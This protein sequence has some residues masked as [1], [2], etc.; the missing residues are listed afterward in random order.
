AAHA[1]VPLVCT[2]QLFHASAAIYEAVEEGSTTFV[3]SLRATHDLDPDL[4]RKNKAGTALHRAMSTK[5]ERE[6]GNVFNTYRRVVTPQIDWYAEGDPDVV[7]DLLGDTH[8]IG[9]R[10]ASG[11]GEVE[12]WEIETDELDGITG[13]FD[14][15]LR[16]VPVE[17]FSGDQTAI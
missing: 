11:F 10:R 3:A 5:R 9:K 14:E 13:H 1:A 16:P 17:M 7:R 4:V 2:N 8:F 12:R 15:P 6:F